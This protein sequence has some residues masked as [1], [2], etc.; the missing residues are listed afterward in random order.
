MFIF[1]LQMERFKTGGGK[2]VKSINEI[3]EKVLEVIEDRVNPLINL[4]DD[5]FGYAGLLQS[6][7][8]MT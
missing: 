6:L 3:S 5:D 8:L 4:Y 1:Q 7:I 2:Y